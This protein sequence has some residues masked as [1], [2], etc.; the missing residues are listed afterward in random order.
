MRLILTLAA[1]SLSPLHAAPL[2]TFARTYLAP[3]N[4]NPCFERLMTRAKT[5]ADRQW[6]MKTAR[7]WS[8]PKNL[9]VNEVP[10]GFTLE[11]GAR[12]LGSVQWISVDPPVIYLNG[13]FKS[14]SP[15][16]DH[17]TSTLVHQ[18]FANARTAQEL[19]LWPRAYAADSEGAL[20]E[21]MTT[22]F[23]LGDLPS[24]AEEYIAGPHHAV[25]FPQVGVLKAWT[26]GERV[27]CGANGVDNLSLPFGTDE[28]MR[29]SGK[30]A[31]Y[32]LRALGK[33]EFLAD[34]VVP[35]KKVVIKVDPGTPRLPC[36]ESGASDQ[37]EKYCTPA[38]TKFFG[39]NP[40]LRQTYDRS[41]AVR[42]DC[43]TLGPEGEA[44]CLAFWRDWSRQFRNYSDVGATRI[45][46]CQD[47]ACKARQP[48]TLKDLGEQTTAA[49]ERETKTQRF[50]ESRQREVDAYVA[51]L[52]DNGI[53]SA[54]TACL[55]LKCREPVGVELLS[56]DK[57]AEA[58]RLKPRPI[59]ET[60]DGV[61][62]QSILQRG[63]MGA[64]VLSE[65]CADKKCRDVAFSRLGLNLS[66]PAGAGTAK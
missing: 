14:A 65:C 4:H 54:D 58:R 10:G 30:S 62:V 52:K 24:T 42:P 18:L 35:G 51:F 46:L 25:T 28:L 5:K 63:A 8:P 1:L 20:M 34:G 6:L 38:W 57:R 50:A 15:P 39:Q 3:A 55:E 60:D 48:M 16:A 31:S 41:G 13:Q 17:A 56:E 64:V 7:T 9:V 26:T 49:P 2:C 47:D 32:T 66:A 12:R 22:L 43:P 44:R 29:A 27:T 40:K 61:V 33:S 53:E 45:S 37:D 11:R 21:Q 23:S 59:N 19:S 36:L